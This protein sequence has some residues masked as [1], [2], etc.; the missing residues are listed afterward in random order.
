MRIVIQ[1]PIKNLINDNCNE[2]PKRFQCITSKVFRVTSR[3]ISN[4]YNSIVLVEAT[5][6]LTCPNLLT[7]DFGEVPPAKFAKFAMKNWQLMDNIM[8]AEFVRI[9]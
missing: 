3:Y 4:V 6:E 8:K 9:R 5:F 1:I 2:C 7:Y